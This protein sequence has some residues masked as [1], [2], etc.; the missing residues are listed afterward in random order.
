MPFLDSLDATLQLSLFQAISGDQDLLPF[1]RQLRQLGQETA[2][3]LNFDVNLR[4]LLEGRRA[5]GVSIHRHGQTETIFSEREVILAGRRLWITSNPDA[6]RHRAGRRTEPVWY[7]CGR[8]SSG[9]NKPSGPSAT[10]DELPHR[11]EIALRR[12]I[13]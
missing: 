10:A 7:S 2:W 6:L 5:T 8:R 11:R 4:L 9:R 12:W 3:Y 1:K 13:T